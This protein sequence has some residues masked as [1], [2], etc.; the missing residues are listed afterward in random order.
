[1]KSYND[2]AINALLDEVER[3]RHERDAYMRAKQENDERFMNERDAAR[4]EV[5]RLKAENERLR[6]FNEMYERSDEHKSD[7]IARLGNEAER[8]SAERDKYM[9]VD[10][11]RRRQMARWR[12]ELA[13][14]TAARDEACDIAEALSRYISIGNSHARVR[15]R[16]ARI[17]TLRKVGQ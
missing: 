1:M 9:S 13:A 6:G 8:L 15:E 10:F 14:M 17:A 5:E 2:I 7:V 12:E 3:L 11:E 16:V 4:N